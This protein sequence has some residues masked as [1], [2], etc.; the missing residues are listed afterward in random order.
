MSHFTCI[1]TEFKDKEVLVESL[2]L[3]GERPNVPTDLGMSVVDLV[4]TNP[5][6]AED[7]PTVEVD[8]A[9]GVDIGF[10]FNEKTGSFEFYSD[11]ATWEKDIPVERFLEKL[12]QQYARMMIH[13]TIKEEGF[14]VQEE[15]EMDDNSIELT[16][17]RWVD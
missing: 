16:V 7:H 4:I 11:H 5:D 3:L 13:R 10:K 15:W 17:N 8:I 14:E 6:H 1:K 12:T 2:E 9:I